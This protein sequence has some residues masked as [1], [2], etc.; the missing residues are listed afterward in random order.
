M[1]RNPQVLN[2]PKVYTGP[3]PSPSFPFP[4]LVH[5]P[6]YSPTLIIYIQILQPMA[7]ETDSHVGIENSHVGIEIFT[8]RRIYTD[9]RL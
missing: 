5:I 1:S 9:K 2:M 3:P 6:D 8:E 7:L 4:T